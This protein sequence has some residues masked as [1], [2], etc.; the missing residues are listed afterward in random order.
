MKRVISC[1]GLICLLASFLA[2]CKETDK[3]LTEVIKN[4]EIV[5]PPKE[6]PR[7][8]KP[9]PLK[10]KE[11]LIDEVE[12]PTRV[13]REKTAYTPREK[14]ELWNT[15][16]R[17]EVKVASEERESWLVWK[18]Y[19]FLEINLLKKDIYQDGN[20]IKGHSWIQFLRYG[21][22][23]KLEGY[24]PYTPLVRVGCDRE[25]G[26]KRSVVWH[27]H[28]L[29][30]FFIPMEQDR[31]ARVANPTYNAHVRDIISLKYDPE[32]DV[33]LL[34][35]KTPLFDEDGANSTYELR[36]REESLVKEFVI[37]DDDH[38]TY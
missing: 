13:I 14:K 28:S 21:N 18:N 8:P 5:M 22:N 26:T 9:V 35:T 34:R 29:S 10:K 24:N 3:D 25:A 7:T 12:T 32:R 33:L 20:L 36:P 31:M 17:Y 11:V 37:P 19:R 30:F 16:Y 15:I 2:S 1:L 6:E 27:E 38:R 4:K 23:E